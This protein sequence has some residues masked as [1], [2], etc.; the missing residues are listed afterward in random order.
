VSNKGEPKMI[1]LELQPNKKNKTHLRIEI[2]YSLGGMCYLSGQC[3]SRGIFAHVAPVAKKDGM[4][5]TAIN[6]AWKN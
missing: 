1:Y 2:S 6:S 4:V 3:S 5:F